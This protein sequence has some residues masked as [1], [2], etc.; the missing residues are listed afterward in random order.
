MALKEK[1]GDDTLGLRG[2][3]VDVCPEGD[4]FLLSIGHTS[5]WF[6]K[7]AAV[8]ILTLLEEALAV[9]EPRRL[10]SKDSN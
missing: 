1:T 4:G 5:I 2:L 6:D 8:L 3:R 7:E 10:A 9:S